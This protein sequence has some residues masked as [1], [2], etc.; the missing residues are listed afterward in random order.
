M[1]QAAPHLN[2]TMGICDDFDEE[3]GSRNAYPHVLM[4]IHSSMH[5]NP[6]EGYE[7]DPPKW[8]LLQVIHHD[9]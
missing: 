3:K 9:M 5:Y 6:F 1:A 4:D 2:G 7:A 8:H